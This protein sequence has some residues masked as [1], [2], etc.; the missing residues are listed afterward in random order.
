M[1]PSM[2]QSHKSQE[3]PSP[4]PIPKVSAR[5]YRGLGDV[6]EAVAKPIAKG[7]DAVLGTDIE[8]CEGCAQRKGLLNDLV[9]FGKE[10]HPAP[11]GQ[12]VVT[13]PCLN[14]GRK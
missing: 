7:I 14:C 11:P 13:T 3:R 6:V 5:K 9:P 8:H 2:E 10:E 4:S 1:K 12:P